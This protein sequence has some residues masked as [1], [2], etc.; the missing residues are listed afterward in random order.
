MDKDYIR[1]ILE[2]VILFLEENQQYGDDWSNEIKALNEIF[3]CHP[4]PKALVACR[5]Q[6]QEDLMCFL[7]GM[8][9]DVLDRVC[10]IVGENFAKLEVTD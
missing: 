4:L 10:D 8:E 1:K 2:N 5:E 7:D 3:W 9:D 6:I